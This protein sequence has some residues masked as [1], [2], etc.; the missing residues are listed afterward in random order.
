MVLG[1]M[2]VVSYHFYYVDD[3]IIGEPNIH[4]PPQFYMLS[5]R[6]RRPQFDRNKMILERPQTTAGQ[7]PIYPESD[8]FQS[9][10]SSTVPLQYNHSASRDHVLAFRY[11]PQDYPK[12]GNAFLTI[13]EPSVLPPMYTDQRNSQ[14]SAVMSTT[15]TTNSY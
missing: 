11:Q 3:P 1:I 7:S 8:S 15:T 5:S 13:P 9:Y 4:H 6:C 2:A 12:G 10:C 14:S